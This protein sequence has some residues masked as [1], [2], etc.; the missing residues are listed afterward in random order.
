L[1]KIPSL[2]PV[3]WNRLCPKSRC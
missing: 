3:S 1:D 2:I